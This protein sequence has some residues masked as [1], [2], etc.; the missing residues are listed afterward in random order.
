VLAA[1][2]S[3]VMQPMARH[4]LPGT[5]ITARSFRLEQRRR[6]ALHRRLVS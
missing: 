2:S 1:S 3:C 5:P 6:T 4:L